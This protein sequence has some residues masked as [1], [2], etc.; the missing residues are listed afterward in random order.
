MRSKFEG[1]EA[2]ERTMALCGA[3]YSEI[4]R[5]YKIKSTGLHDVELCSFING[6]WYAFQ[7]HG[8]NYAAMNEYTNS[9]GES[10]KMLNNERIKLEEMIGILKATLESERID[11]DAGFK[12]FFK[13]TDISGETNG[14]SHIPEYDNISGYWHKTQGRRYYIHGGEWISKDEAS[15]TLIPVV[16]GEE[17]K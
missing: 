5:N 14:F 17:V 8:K 6:A 9:Q 7:E 2:I 1:L 16:N 12:I 10:I 11:R 15:K 13:A 4:T 3:T